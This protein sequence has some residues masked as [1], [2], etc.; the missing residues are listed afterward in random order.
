MTTIT[1]FDPVFRP[2]PL[3]KESFFEF[4]VEELTRKTT[5][6]NLS[7]ALT[8]YDISK[9]SRERWIEEMSGLPN[10]Y[11]MNMPMLAAALVLLNEFNKDNAKTQEKQVVIFQEDVDAILAKVVTKSSMTD[12]QLARQKLDVLRYIRRI[13][14]YR[15]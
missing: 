1:A 12:E 6:G 10:F 7:R 11:R 13:Q 15:S 8:N 3:S 14:S 4:D 2:V 5:V 9:Q